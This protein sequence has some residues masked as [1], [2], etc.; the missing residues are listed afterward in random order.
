MI[1]YANL[2]LPQNPQEYPVT[3]HVEFSEE[4]QDAAAERRRLALTKTLAAN[5]MNLNEAASV[6][7]LNTASSIGNFLNRRT[8]SL[9]VATYEPLAR[10]LGVTINEL[11]GIPEPYPRD[12]RNM[13]E[14]HWYSIKITGEAS[15]DRRVSSPIWQESKW[16]TMK[17]PDGLGKEDGSRYLVIS[18]DE[19][20]LIFKP[21]TV[22]EVIDLEFY[23]GQIKHGSKV[24]VHRKTSDGDYEVSCREV[25]IDGKSCRIVARSNRRRWRYESTSVAWPIVAGQTQLTPEGHTIEIKAVVVRSIRD[26][27]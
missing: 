21:G 15:T 26:E 11:V 14:V 8:S 2:H 12:R 24:I 23:D 19:M 27:R 25:R 4:D 10:H 7:G 22:V 13:V 9:N 6:A 17:M 3:V 18:S 1:V 20:N 5:N 16:I